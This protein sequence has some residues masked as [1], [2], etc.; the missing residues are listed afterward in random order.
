M[1]P[2]T[3]HFEFEGVSFNSYFTPE[4]HLMAVKDF[5]MTAED[6]LIAGYPRTGKRAYQS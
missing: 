1:E 2:A 5:E 4:D 3:G 6:V